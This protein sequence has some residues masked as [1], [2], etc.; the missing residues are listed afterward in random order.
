MEQ[1]NQINLLD[2]FNLWIRESISVK[3]VSIGFLILILLIPNSWIQDLM[4]ER[5][6]RA[7]DVIQEVAQKW[8]ESQTISGPILIIPYLHTEEI[9]YTNG[10]VK[11]AESTINAYFLPD[12]LNIDGLVKPETLSRGIFDVAVYNSTL[13]IKANFTYPNFSSIGVNESQVK[14]DEAYLVAG[15]SD[16]KGINNSPLIMAGEIE[17]DSG[18]SNNIG[19]LLPAFSNKINPHTADRMETSIG[20][21]KGIK[22]R[23]NWKT[24]ND[25]KSEVIFNIDIKGS[26]RLNF[27]PIGK[28]TNVHITG[29][30]RDPSFDGE[31]LPVTR[32]ITESN[33]TANWKVLHFNRPFDQAWTGDDMELS[34]SSFGVKL[35]IP[36]DQYQKSIRSSKY[37]ILIILLTFVSLFLVEIIAKIRIH[38]FQYILIGSALIIYYTL[39]ISISEYLGYNAAYWIATVLTVGLLAFYSKS[40]MP[41][42]KLAYLFSLIVLLS[43]FFI[44]IIII[45]QDLSL[46]IGSLGLFIVAGLIM[47]F[48][49]KINWY[50]E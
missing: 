38:P 32:E 3:L 17:L 29:P 24:K 4:L 30:W 33:F 9:K 45:Q 7:D 26:N 37:S 43:Y 41:K 50:G 28:T 19:L 23:L 25:F 15:I 39:L 2:R 1:K 47:Y 11:T 12:E 5:Q 42:A 21:R 10:E 49:R 20:S 34:N 27:I 40:F 14:W 35:L 13:K 22:S 46:L 6:Q 31:F 18:P 44:F 36:V 16:L 8:S 48:S